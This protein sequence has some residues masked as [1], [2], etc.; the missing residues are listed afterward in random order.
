MILAAI[1]QLRKP[2]PAAVR[3]QFLRAC[4]H[5][6]SQLKVSARPVLIRPSW[7]EPRHKSKLM[8][9]ISA[10]TYSLDCNGLAVLPL[11]ACVA[12]HINV[13]L[14]MTR[15]DFVY[16][17]ARLRLGYENCCYWLIMYD[18]GMQPRA[19]YALCRHIP[20]TA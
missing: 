3:T 18:L 20:T 11:G 13:H 8:G 10:L 4:L 14:R 12:F 2:D 6:R 15:G 17:T 1:N 16:S 19:E 7:K 9:G 5:L